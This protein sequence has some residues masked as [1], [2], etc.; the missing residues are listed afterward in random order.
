M[1]KKQK[2]NGKGSTRSEFVL[3]ALVLSLLFV[4]VGSNLLLTFNGLELT[5][6]GIY[7]IND[8]SWKD[9][10]DYYLDNN[11]NN[12]DNHRIDS[13]VGASN[14]I[15]G[16]AVGDNSNGEEGLA[17]SS[18]NT[19]G[20]MIG[21]FNEANST[22]CGN[23]TSNLTL[24]ANVNSTATCFAFNASGVTLDCAGYTVTYNN[25]GG[26]TDGI[27]NNDGFDNITIKNCNILPK[28]D[29][30]GNQ[31]AVLFNYSNNVIFINNTI[32]TTGGTHNDCFRSQYGD[33]PIVANNTCLV[34][35]TGHNNAGLRVFG[36]LGGTI[37]NNNITVYGNDTSSGISLDIRTSYSSF[38]NHTVV[39][40]NLIYLRDNWTSADGILGGY[41][42]TISFNNITIYAINSSYGIDL[43]STSSVVEDNIITINGT[44]SIY[45]VYYQLSFNDTTARNT[46]RVNSTTLGY[47][48]RSGG[49]MISNNT[50]TVTG[51]GNNHT[52]I[53]FNGGFVDIN[54]VVENNIV[55]VYGASNNYALDSETACCEANVTFQ[56]N[57]LTSNGTGSNN[58]GLYIGNAGGDH[59]YNN[60]IRSLSGAYSIF[61]SNG[62]SGADYFRYSNTFGKISWDEKVDNPKT[63]DNLTTNAT[64]IIGNGIFLQD[65]LIGVADVPEI[66]FLNQT[67]NITF[68]GLT[69]SGG[70]QL[71]RN[72]VVCGSPACN[73]TYV[74]QS[75]TLSAAV[76]SFSNYTTYYES[77]LPNVTNLLPTLNYKANTTLAV[78]IGANITDANKI[79]LA[80]VNVTLPNGTINVL[81][82]SNG[83]TF[84]DK[85][86]T[87]FSLTWLTGDYNVTF[88]GTD[89][90]G[91]VNSTQWTNFSV[92]V[93]CGTISTE[94]QTVT[95]DQNIVTT[96]NT[97]F[98]VQAS[99]VIINGNSYLMTGDLDGGGDVA[100]VLL[101]NINHTYISNLNV[102]N[103]AS[104]IMLNNQNTSNHT[105]NNS[106]FF[107]QTYYGFRI[108]YARNVT[109]KNI[110]IPFINGTALSV[111]DTDNLYVDNFSVR[112][113]R[114]DTVL[115]LSQSNKYT[116]NVYFNRVNITNGNN[117]VY[118]VDNTSLLTI[119]NSAFYNQSG[120]VIS[121]LAD[122]LTIINS[123][124]RNVSGISV[125]GAV[126]ITIFNNT[127]YNV[128]PN[129]HFITAINVNIS[130]NSFNQSNLLSFGNVEGATIYNNMFYC[131]SCTGIGVSES[132]SMNHT[133][134][135]GN[136][137]TGGM[138]N[139]GISFNGVKTNNITISDNY[140]NNVS[141]EASIFLNNTLDIYINSNNYTNP[142]SSFVA[143]R[144]S[145]NTYVQ[146]NMINVVSASYRFISLDSMLKMII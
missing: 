140:F 116:N 65:N 133:T 12:D 113:T 146:H 90:F 108:Q 87:S 48:I 32:S 142:S 56:N 121:S 114:A 26:G 93:G 4:F 19:G 73:F 68:Y 1:I 22:S 109:I 85:W 124:F 66:G 122:D 143:L 102:T 15:T 40:G 86:N 62:S 8:R 135:K 115:T 131:T 51:S 95:L 132:Y 119:N 38:Q 104:G 101:D 82:L 145:N 100:A 139:G 42:S 67:P 20:G 13:P 34:N 58:Y 98:T 81:T 52:G 25:G 144:N 59:Y 49:D 117:A 50:V 92:K 18:E 44:S 127:F 6:D 30:T 107:N 69:A 126:N 5:L 91:N 64:L 74:A 55:N 47:G 3:L 41:N 141:G 89:I 14:L 54:P 33:N 79:S 80:T 28:V 57:T 99:G 111:S 61:D 63:I 83:T 138:S 106:V 112:D 45:G 75:T 129:A 2:A 17:V 39:R 96:D 118:A 97:C 37:S 136:N 46:I 7:V 84:V 125:T 35:G 29:I 43:P 11:Q 120:A 123:Q 128:T 94:G 70:K 24:T 76:N 134:I 77:V 71:L 23:I 78:E 27:T 53:I 36:G 72:G 21:I 137:F 105:I 130:Q 110:H 10:L 103:F 31:R 16:A 88:I 9:S 60:S